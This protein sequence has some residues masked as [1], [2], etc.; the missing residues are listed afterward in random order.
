MRVVVA[1]GGE[2]TSQSALNRLHWHFWRWCSFCRGR[3]PLEEFDSQGYRSCF[4]ARLYICSKS[5]IPNNRFAPRDGLVSVETGI[6]TQTIS[7]QTVF[8][9]FHT[10]KECFAPSRIGLGYALVENLSS[11][12]LQILSALTLCHLD[13]NGSL[14]QAVLQCSWPLWRK[15]ALPQR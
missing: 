1:S 4:E 7:E 2:K 11:S 3:T 8:E 13:E 15:T 14:F 12:M 9:C 5:L 10:K 6:L